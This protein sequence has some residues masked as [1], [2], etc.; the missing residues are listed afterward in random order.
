MTQISQV[1]FQFLLNLKHL[2]DERGLSV[3]SISVHL[4]YSLQ[5]KMI[6]QITLILVFLLAFMCEK[7]NYLPKV[8]FSAINK[9]SKLH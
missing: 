9:Y 1:V 2:G 7:R 6:L 4:S 3:V 8:A 5:P